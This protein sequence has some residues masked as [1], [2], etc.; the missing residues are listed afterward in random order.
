[1]DFLNAH[2]AGGTGFPDPDDVA[3]T[4]RRR[5]RLRDQGFAAV[6]A[7]RV[8]DLRAHCEDLSGGS[9]PVEMIPVVRVV[10]RKPN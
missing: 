10:V 4:L 2:T 5:V 1:V 9:G 3:N 8:A 7:G 6:Q